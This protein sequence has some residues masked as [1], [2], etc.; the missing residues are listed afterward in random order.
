MTESAFAP[1]PAASYDFEGRVALVTGGARGIG[2]ASAL[3]LARHGAAVAVAD[4]LGDAEQTVSEIEALGG[5]GLWIEVDVGE[6][7]RV[8]AMVEQVVATFGRLDFAHNNAGVFAPA[9]LADLA[10]EEFDRVVRVNLNGVFYCLK[11]EIL[12]MR[13]QGGGAIVNTAS[14]W[15]FL[16]AP[17]QASYAASKHGVLG[18]TRTAAADHAADGIRVNAVAPGPI[19]TAMTASVPAEILE[20]IVQRS[21]EKRIGQPDEIARAVAWLC[22]GGAAYVNGVTIPVDG[23]WLAA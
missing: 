2:R 7:G 18:L 14:I 13:E 9:P 19:E 16:G 15:S 4:L 12:R 1:P 8:A 3:E 5:R 6:A 11:H 22:S 20:A 17:A 21:A 23:G 10:E